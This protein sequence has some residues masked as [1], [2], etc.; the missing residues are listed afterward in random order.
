MAFC[1]R[2]HARWTT[3]RSS[4]SLIA[5][6]RRYS[7]EVMR[8]IWRRRTILHLAPDRDCSHARRARFPRKTS[9]HQAT[10]EVEVK[11]IARSSA[12]PT[13]MSSRFS[14]T[15]PNTSPVHAPKCGLQLSLQA[16][17][18]LLPG[19]TSGFSRKGSDESYMLRSS[20]GD[21]PSG[22]RPGSDQGPRCSVKKFEL[23]LN[24]THSISGGRRYLRTKEVPA[25]QRR[26]RSA[27]IPRRPPRRHR[28][29]RCQ[30]GILEKVSSCACASSWNN[31]INSVP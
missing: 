21:V 14:A 24:Y 18:S 17:E 3:L 9:H 6:D 19:H 7:R 26:G 23:K 11:R 1:M 16:L 13:T 2:F 10:R 22:S 29:S 27:Q 31:N 5:H 8:E 28:S 30:T 25:G 20:G 15:L 12:R 4:A